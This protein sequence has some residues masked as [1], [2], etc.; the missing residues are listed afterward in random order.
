MA[1]GGWPADQGACS[2]M[3]R[4]VRDG[5]RRGDGRRR[6]LLLL[7][8]RARDGRREQDSLAPLYQIV[9]AAYGTNARHQIAFA[10]I[11]C[12]E[13]R[14]SREKNTAVGLNFVFPSELLGIVGD[15]HFFSFGIT[16]EELLK[17]N[18]CQLN[19]PKLLELLLCHLKEPKNSL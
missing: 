15:E 16:F 2:F 10:K 17:S 9:V 11:W 6:C 19:Y 13:C 7:P 18:I 5:R 12:G 8:Q 4:R 3:P 1:R 14:G